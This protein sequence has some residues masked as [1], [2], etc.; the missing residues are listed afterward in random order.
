MDTVTCLRADSGRKIWSYACAAGSYPGPKATPTISSGLVYTLG[1]ECHLF[2]LD[3]LTGA[4][5]WARH[6]VKDLGITLPD[7]DIAGSPIVFSDLLIINAD[8]SDLAL[9]KATGAK[10]WSSGGGPGGYAAPVLADV[11]GRTLAVIFDRRAVY[12]VDARSGAAAWSFEWE[13]GSY[14]NAADPLV[15]R[16]TVFVASAYGKGSALYDVSGPRPVAVWSNHSFETHFS[17]FVQI[18]GCL[19]LVDSDARVPGA[20]TLRCVEAKT[21][22]ID[23][24]RAAGLRFARSGGRHP[25]RAHGVGDARRGGC[26]PAGLQRALARHA[27]ARPVM[28]PACAGEEHAFRSGTQGRTVRDRREVAAWEK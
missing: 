21:G 26:E 17:S 3:T 28:D 23:W 27:A 9:D 19:C 4:V 14:A 13:T 18:D 1:R 11:R 15:M 16:D 8:R 20:G 10:V 2:A 25:R 7:Y 12:G 22:K 24:E 5:H 6:L